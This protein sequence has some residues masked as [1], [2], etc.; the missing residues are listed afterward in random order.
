MHTFRLLGEIG[1]SDGDGREVD[2]LL[3]KPKHAALLAYLAMPRPGTW[4]RRD[5]ILATFWPENE[6]GRGRAA[7]RS[8]LLVLRR[9]LPEGAI[10]SRGDDELSLS[11]DVVATDVCAM[12]EDIVAGRF[13]E[14]LERYR[15]ELLPGLYVADAEDFDKWLEQERLRARSLA[16]RA[17]SQLSLVQESSGDLEGALDAA[18]RAAEL[19]PHDETSVRRWIALLDRVGDRAQA[20]A[21]YERFRN[22]MAEA[23]GVRPSAETVALLD[24]VRTRH[25]ST[26]PLETRTA[27]GER[28][29][30]HR[31]DLERVGDRIFPAVT[32]S[33]PSVTPAARGRSR[34]V[35]LAATVVATALVAFAMRPQESDVA[36]ATAGRTLV[37]LPMDDETGDSALA[38]VASGI[39]DGVARRLEG[40]GGLRIR[41]GA[42]SRWPMATRHD[43]ETIGRAMGS[44]MLLRT[45]MRRTEDALEVRASVVDAETYVERAIASHRFSLSEIRDVESRL[46]AE[47][48]GALFRIPMPSVP[49]DP[50]RDLDE[51]SYALML[52]GW[53]QF[54]VNER[55]RPPAN[56]RT[57]FI[58]AKRLF[59]SAVTI[60]PR[61]ARA[62][63]GLSTIWGNQAVVDLVPFEEGYALSTVAA[64]RALAIDS[65]QGSALANLAIMRALKYRDLKAGMQL[66][67]KAEEAEPSNPEVF[68]IKSTI[69][70]SA[71][72]Y[73]EA[74]DAARV[75]RQLDPLNPNMRVREG[76]TEFCAGHPDAALK[77]FQSELVLNPSDAAS[78][79][80][81]TRAL[82][83]LGR[84]DE[85]IVSWRG[86]AS[87]AGDSGLRMALASVSGEAGYW[88]V[89]HAEGRK[90]L[91]QLRKEGG[92]RTS[93]RLVQ[94]AFGSG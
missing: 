30:P 56:G 25:E 88:A 92:R 17:A 14:G 91:A 23:F 28:D 13:A 31:P 64:E 45:A 67:R 34:W 22:Q 58:T 83:L 94:A 48:A 62:Y 79:N 85:A 51:R 74:R 47:V 35:W 90:R 12:H 26:A 63:S 53:H 68:L 39:A 80:G 5:A 76:E 81:L 42:R 57:R 18:R 4:H 59:D 1:L 8:A 29:V 32:R 40:L 84:F 55:I 86:Q 89:R 27:T 41:S 87:T 38:Y 3:R 44:T 61:N 43:I 19:S 50:D 24:A 6:Q 70:L 71:H 78:R 37:V 20:F 93:I 33:V 72:R 77:L 10:I 21:V 7:L 2:E 49:R 9:G 54:F 11:A 66:I 16:H 65:L 73:E 15:G 69:L 46:A 60:D 82:A 36:S 52:Q 75:A